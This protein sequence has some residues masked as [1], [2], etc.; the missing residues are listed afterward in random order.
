MTRTARCGALITIAAAALLGACARPSVDPN[1]GPHIFAD[2]VAPIHINFSCD[3]AN[4]GIQVSLIDDNGNPAW[5][6]KAKK[7]D[8]VSWLVPANVTINSISPKDPA[9]PLPISPNGN[10]GHSNGRSYDVKVNGNAPGSNV[11]YPYNIDVSCTPPGGGTPVR[12][13]IDPDMIIL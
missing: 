11:H 5:A 3:D 7:N 10:S 13:V 4:K 8:P 12:L 2:A 1:G 9:I 6:F